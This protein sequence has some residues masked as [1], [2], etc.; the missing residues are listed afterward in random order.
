LDEDRIELEIIRLVP[1]PVVV[2]PAGHLARRICIGY[3]LVAQGIHAIR[4]R[5]VYRDVDV[6]DIVSKPRKSGVEMV[7]NSGI[8]GA[9]GDRKGL[10]FH[11]HR[12]VRWDWDRARDVLAPPWDAICGIFSTQGA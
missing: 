10:V 5:A 8:I 11:D 4:L 3:G 9:E 7:R 12:S 2:F 6:V 1:V